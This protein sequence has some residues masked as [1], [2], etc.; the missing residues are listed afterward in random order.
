MP[1]VTRHPLRVRAAHEAA[2]RRCDAEAKSFPHFNKDGR[3][4]TRH[5]M[6][7]VF[8]VRSRWRMAARN[9]SISRCPLVKG[10]HSRR[11]HWPEAPALI[12]LRALHP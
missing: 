8:G 2:V 11:L 12:F 9:R 6:P 7:S 10:G 3:R 5:A 1:R 4:S